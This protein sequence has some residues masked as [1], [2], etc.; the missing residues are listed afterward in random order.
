[1]ALR[2]IRMVRRQAAACAAAF[3]FLT[4][5]PVPVQ[6]QYDDAMFRRSVIWYPLVGAV[7]GV[8]VAALGALLT[9]WAGLSAE[10]SAALVLG[11]W[12]ALTGALHLD[13]LMDTADG[14]LS[15]RSRERM[16]EIMKDS[17]V[18]AMGVV[19]CVLLLLVKWTLLSELL[20]SVQSMNDVE[21]A[22]RH[23]WTA[24]SGSTWLALLPLAA[25]WSRWWMVAAVAGFPYARSTDEAGAGLGG[26]FRTVRLRHAVASF[27]VGV[28]V[29]GMMLYAGM[30][31][32]WVQLPA[33]QAVLVL[34][35]CIAVTCGIGFWLSRVMT[36][37][38]GGLTGDTY[39]AMNEL[40]EASL[41][42]VLV[43]MAG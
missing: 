37:K 24:G 34:L 43:L 18:G 3:Q 6:L 10:V 21:S 7:L 35:V 9:G 40:L 30:R 15:H 23:P 29:S 33:M 42:L 13:G 27:L 26:L 1:M 4:R 19:A 14:L 38:L 2:M 17:R 32:G 11:C 28:S 31:L 39:G 25:I 36:R 20:H 8:I 22:R 5:L 12:V 41:L 16:L